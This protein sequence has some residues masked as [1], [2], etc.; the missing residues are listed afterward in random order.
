MMN[1]TR[2]S[3]ALLSW[4]IDVITALSV[5]VLLSAWISDL[6]SNQA[7][8]ISASFLQNGFCLSPL[9]DSTHIICSIFDACGGTIFIGIAMLSGPR[10]RQFLLPTG[11]YVI[12]H[13]YGH[14][15]MGTELV[16]PADMDADEVLPL[17][18]IFTLAAILSLGPIS[19]ANYLI[20]A[21][22]MR[23][24]YANI[25]LAITKG[26]IFP[27]THVALVSLTLFVGLEMGLTFAGASW[28]RCGLIAL[29]Q[30]TSNF[31]VILSVLQFDKQSLLW[32]DYTTA[33]VLCLCLSG[34]W[35]VVQ[36]EIGIS[37]KIAAAVS[38]GG[39]GFTLM[40]LFCCSIISKHVGPEEYI[41]AV[42]FILFPEA[43][44]FLPG[45][46]DPSKETETKEETVSA[47]VYGG[48]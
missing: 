29:G 31:A 27:M 21:G 7:N 5:L 22:K 15:V 40:V 13:A 32:L 10:I 12:S 24:R 6:R 3:R 25:G 11:A 41:L 23:Q 26:A 45:H 38:L 44:L 37:W 48:A 1:L 14:Y 18:D 19:G 2:Q 33:A 35:T 47:T 34:L 9:F 43:L 4:Q 46:D 16:K 30:A 42:L 28:G 17:R 39:W 8:Y 36:A 20:K